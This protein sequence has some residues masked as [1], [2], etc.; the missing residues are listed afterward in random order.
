MTAN[1]TP[2][3]DGE[4]G[5]EQRTLKQYGV[6]GC[7]QTTLDTATDGG[8]H[9]PDGSD[10][11]GDDA[12]PT[13]QHDFEYCPGPSGIEFPDE[14]D[15]GRFPE[16]SNG[17]FPC[18][19]CYMKAAGQQGISFIEDT[20]EQVSEVVS[21]WS[22]QSFEAEHGDDQDNLL[23]DGGVERDAEDTRSAT[24]SELA[25]V[26]SLLRGCTFKKHWDTDHS[27]N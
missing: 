27:P 24:A 6:K 26:E 8:E 7:D 13:C 10:Q 5:G 3:S 15:E 4:A 22:E 19:R 11:G 18:F 1:V 25:E 12:P 21:T 16:T 23:T 17:H 9:D 14:D 2:F 20:D